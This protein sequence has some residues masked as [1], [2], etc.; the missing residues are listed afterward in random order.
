MLTCNSKAHTIPND[1][2]LNVK[3]EKF[4]TQDF[5]HEK[6]IMRKKG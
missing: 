4:Q 1:N 2:I 3:W 6:W 5:Q